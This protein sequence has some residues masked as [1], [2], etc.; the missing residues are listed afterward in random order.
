YRE[1]TGRHQE[2]GWV[3]GSHVIE[4]MPDMIRFL[5]EC[6]EVLAHTGTLSLAVSD[7]RYCFD[8]LRPKSTLSSIIDAHEQRRT[9]HSPGSAAEYFLNVCTLQAGVDWDVA[10]SFDTSFIHTLEE[11]KN[12]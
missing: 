6:D 4:R 3:I 10:T 5:Q 1:L 2:Y 11:A 7:K 8:H 12:G 9:T